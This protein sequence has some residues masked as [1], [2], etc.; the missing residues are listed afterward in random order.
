VLHGREMGLTRIVHMEAHLLDHVGDVRLGEGDIMESPD[1]AAVSSWVTDGPPCRMRPWP[2]CRL[3]WSRACSRSCQ[4][5]QG[6][7]ER[8]DVGEGRGR[9]V[10][11]PLRR[12]RSGEGGRCLL[13]WFYDT[14]P[15]TAI[16]AARGGSLIGG[17]KTLPTQIR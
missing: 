13:K 1:Q 9:Q 8:T 3:A 2:E 4:L 10:A 17:I 11:A 14:S 16:R 12:Q 6:C 7:P 15:D 5:T